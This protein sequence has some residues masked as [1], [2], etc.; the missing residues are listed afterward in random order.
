MAMLLSG[1]QCFPL[2]VARSVFNSVPSHTPQSTVTSIPR[3]HHPNHAPRAPRTPTS[4]PSSSAQQR[5]GRRGRVR[6]PSD[7]THLSEAT[8]S[9]QLYVS[10]AGLTIGL[11]HGSIEAWLR[12]ESA[13]CQRHAFNPSTLDNPG[14]LDQI[15]RLLETEHRNAAATWLA[16]KQKIHSKPTLI[17]TPTITNTRTELTCCKQKGSAEPAGHHHR[18]DVRVTTIDQDV[19]SK[20]WSHSC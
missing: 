18:G 4:I 14:G 11:H 10:Q 1:A 7:S 13:T 3:F 2:F 12:G 17:L 16:D 5:L 15:L 19:A 9:G 20:S 6:R 8:H